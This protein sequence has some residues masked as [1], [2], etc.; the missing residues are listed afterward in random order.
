MSIFTKKKNIIMLWGYAKSRGEISLAL[1]LSFF[2]G[3]SGG[4]RSH[5]RS[6]SP[7]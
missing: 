6:N 3:L 4:T 7:T 5:H 1:A 2:C